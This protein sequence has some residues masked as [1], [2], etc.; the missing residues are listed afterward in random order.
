MR[1]YEIHVFELGIEMNFQCMLESQ[2]GL[3]F[4]GLSRF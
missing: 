2:S 4:S 1:V 3:I